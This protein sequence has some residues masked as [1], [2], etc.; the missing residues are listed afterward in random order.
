MVTQ[1]WDVNHEA[2]AALVVVVK[3]KGI[4]ALSDPQLMLSMLRDLIPGLPK[5]SNILV[6]AAEEDVAGMLRDRLAQ[7]ISTGAAVTQAAVLLEERTALALDGCQWAVRLMA[8]MIGLPVEADEARHY[9]NTQTWPPR[10]E[11]RPAPQPV[12]QPAPQPVPQPA[13]QPAPR[14]SPP[15]VP[16]PGPQPVPQ[17]VPRPVPQP[18]PPPVPRPSPPA[19]SGP[20]LVAGWAALACAL[21]V[22]LQLLIN[23]SLTGSYSLELALFGLILFTAA[24]L[25]LRGKS[26]NLGVGMAFGAPLAVVPTFL[27]GSVAPGLGKGFVAACVIT[28]VIAVIAAVS[29]IVYFRGEIRAGNLRNPLAAAYSLAALGF[30][31][32]A[33]PG[34]FQ[35]NS[36]SG[37]VTVTGVLGS[38]VHGWALF[39]GILAVVAL[40]PLAVLPGLLPA[41][42]GIRAG[43]IAGS[44]AVAVAGLIGDTLFAAGSGE[45]AANGLYASWALW[46]ITLA[47]GVALLARDRSRPRVTAQPVLTG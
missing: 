3:E 25:T 15:P 28:T 17:P 43:L 26:R 36:G 33:I 27:G 13:P 42:T 2:H 8:Q 1:A 23:G 29:S 44:L 34:R 35:Y 19:R 4:T 20:A 40:L 16:Q 37:W 45:R 9:Q 41:G 14:L 24:M 38:G 46:G 11:I 6:H 39:A 5:E 10:E 12:P 7:H 31:V 32:A 18:G 21:S 22:P 30:I 47:L